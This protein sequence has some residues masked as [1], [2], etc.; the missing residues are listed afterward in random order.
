MQIDADYY[1]YRD[2]QDGLLV[3]LEKAAEEKGTIISIIVC[4]KQV[5][6]ISARVAIAEAIEEWKQSK[7]DEGVDPDEA[8]RELGLDVNGRPL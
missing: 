2:D 3:A 4:R 1:V 5:L 6:T 7:R 8:L